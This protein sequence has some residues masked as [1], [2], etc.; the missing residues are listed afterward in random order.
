MLRVRA[1]TTESSFFSKIYKKKFLRKNAKKR[2]TAL[3][4]EESC[5]RNEKKVER[6]RGDREGKGEI[7][8]EE[9]GNGFGL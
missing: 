4:A 2:P 6:G 1:K 8:R 5:P 9:W 3:H 7:E